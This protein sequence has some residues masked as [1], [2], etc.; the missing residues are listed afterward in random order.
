MGFLLS[1]ARLNGQF[2]HTRLSTPRGP[3]QIVLD[4]GITL[5]HARTSFH[6]EALKRRDVREQAMLRCVLSP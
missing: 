2:P 4:T 6:E 5:A 3:L 1:K